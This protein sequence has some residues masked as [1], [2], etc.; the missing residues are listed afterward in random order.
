M[1]RDLPQSFALLRSDRRMELFWGTTS[2]SLPL[3]RKRFGYRRLRI[4]TI[5]GR[6]WNNH[7]IACRLEFPL[8]LRERVRVRGQSR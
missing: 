5:R 7:Q 4:L 6:A 8:P 3:H 1:L 2:S